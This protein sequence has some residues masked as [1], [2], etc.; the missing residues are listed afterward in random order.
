MSVFISKQ[1]LGI[2]WIGIED[3]ILIFLGSVIIDCEVNRVQELS[4]RCL[5]KLEPVDEIKQTCVA[6]ND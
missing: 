2:S 4:I 1:G 3:Q 6:F 5:S